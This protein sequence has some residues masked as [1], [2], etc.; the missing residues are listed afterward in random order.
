MAGIYTRKAIAAILNDD[1]LTPEER[2]DQLFSLYGRAI[3]DGYI[4][5]SASQAAVQAA[6]E[7]AKQDAIKEYK[8]PDPKESEVY[9]KLQKDFEAY[10]ARQDARLS[11]DFANVKPKFFDS[12]Y[13]KLDRSDGAKPVKEQL[14]S[15]KQ[16]FEEYFTPTE[17][18][19]PATPQFASQ[20]KGEMPKGDGNGTFASYWGYRKE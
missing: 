17:E 18:T 3:D 20:T 6:I 19:K 11:E 13:E 2:T 8:A 4:T 10:K 9:I 14:E 1:A 12:V 5:K 16:N 15:I 7:Q